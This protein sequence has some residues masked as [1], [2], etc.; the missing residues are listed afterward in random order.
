MGSVAVQGRISLQELAFGQ[1]FSAND[2]FSYAGVTV[3][4][5]D[6]AIA[7]GHDLGEPGG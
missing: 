1:R 6:R 5:K 4:R 3:G 2:A 7:A